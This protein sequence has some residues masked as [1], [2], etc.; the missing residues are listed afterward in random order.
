M[1]R[2]FIALFFGLIFT[3]VNNAAMAASFNCTKATLPTEKAICQHLSLNDQ[4]VKMATTFNVLTRVLP[5]G[6]RD[7][8]RDEQSIWLK[9]R[10]HCGQRI[11]CIQMSYISR[12]QQLDQ[13]LQQRVYSHGPF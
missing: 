10:N 1:L 4:D 6:G 7:A 2:L 13:M 8:L 5:M 12:Q 11:N 9:Q 3:T